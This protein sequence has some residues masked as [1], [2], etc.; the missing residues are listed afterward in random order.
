MSKQVPARNGGTLTRPDKGETMNPNGRPRRTV[1][2][3]LDEGEKQGIGRVSKEDVTH[4][5]ELVV[6]L[7]EDK[8]KHAMSDKDAPML[9]RIVAKALLDKRGFD[10]LETMLN[11][12]QGKPAQPL[13]GP[14]GKDLPVP[15]FQYVSNNDSDKKDS[16]DEKQN[17]GGVRRDIS[18]QD[19]LNNA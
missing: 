2:V 18:I 4:A 14:N 17:T 1:R 7:T 16:S 9:V 6:N 5:Y 8:M 15:I 12:S 11:R 3:I 19:D 13:T 10:I